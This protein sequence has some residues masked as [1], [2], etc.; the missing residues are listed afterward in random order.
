MA[1]ARDHKAP[2]ELVKEVAD[3]GKLPVVNFAAESHVD[4]SIFA[5]RRFVRTNVEGTLNLLE[6]ARRGGVRRF[7]YVSS[8]ASSC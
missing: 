7:L 6:A 2:Y 8:A 5:A 1:A 3:T 4:R